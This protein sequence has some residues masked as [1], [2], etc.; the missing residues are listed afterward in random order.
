MARAGTKPGGDRQQVPVELPGTEF[1]RRWS[2]HILPKNYF[3]TRR[4]GGYS[5]HHR[6]RYLAQCRDLLKLN[7]DEPNQVPDI[8]SHD[9]PAVN[10]TDKPPL[11]ERAE[12]HCPKC[13]EAMLLIASTSR[14]SWRDVMRSKYRP[15]WYADR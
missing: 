3:K 8:E 9:V 13:G 15:R 10:L 14:P 2:L 7:D 4:Y 6:K 1:V 11:R 5:N 12:C